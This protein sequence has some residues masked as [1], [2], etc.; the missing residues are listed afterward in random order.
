[1]PTSEHRR[2]ADLNNDA[3]SW[4]RWGPYV[5]DRAWATVR[6]DYSPDGEAWEYFP[7]EHAHRRAYRWGED[8]IGAI[9]DRYQTL[10]FA[11][12]FWNGVDPI[13]KERLFGVTPKQANHGE[14]VK[15]YYFYLDNTPTHSYMRM[16]YKYP[17]RAFPYQELVK[18]N[19]CRAGTGLEYELLDTG[20]FDDDRYFDITIEYAKG[21]EE[22]LCIRIEA[23]NRGPVAATLH[24]LP[25][26]W[27]RNTWAWTTPRGPEPRIEL[28]SMQGKAIAITADDSGLPPLPELPVPYCLERRTLYGPS[29][30]K[31]LF[32]NNETDLE[33][34]GTSDSP[35][36]KDA[37]HRH[38]IAGEDCVNSE[39]YG[40]KS[41][42]QYVFKDIPPGRSA[43]L[44]LRLTNRELSDPLAEVDSIVEQRRSEADEFYEAIHPKT[45]TVDERRIQRQALAGLLWSKQIYLFHVDR[46]LEGDDSTSPPP[47]ERRQIRNHHWRHLRSMRIM[48]MPDKWEYPW[49]AA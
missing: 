28:A 45:A 25:Q 49:F 4:R 31:A 43:V 17:Q 13:L 14:D 1:M 15:E 21:D 10:V 33:V 20:I 44:R 24:V 2:L 18:E 8:G 46:W 11:P 38:I 48:S 23:V 29:G 37:F 35:Y 22:D 5:S 7:F 3:D 41:A 30:G 32:T 16:L 26:L 9:C 12:A 42:I 34:G 27:F 36:T 19:Q 47:S 6:E 40:T 39:Q